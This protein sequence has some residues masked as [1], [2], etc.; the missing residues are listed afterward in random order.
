MCP[1]LNP[2]HLDARKLRP[3]FQR[4]ILVRPLSCQPCPANTWKLSGTHLVSS[5]PCN[6]RAI[7]ERNR[8]R[9]TSPSAN[10]FFQRWFHSAVSCLSLSRQGVSDEKFAAISKI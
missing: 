8:S 1:T 7:K 10:P 3:S 2:F 5:D 6:H 4:R 9:N